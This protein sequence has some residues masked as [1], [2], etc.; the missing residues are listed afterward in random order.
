MTLHNAKGLEY[1]AVFIIGC[2]DGVFPHQRSIDEGDIEEERRLAYVGLTRAREHLALS[3]ARRRTVFGAAGS[4]IPSRFLNEIPDH[5]IER[6][7]TVGPPTGWGLGGGSGGYPS[8]GFSLDTPAASEPTL[9][10]A[11]GDDVVHAAFGEGIVTAV[12]PG[13]VVVVRFGRGGEERK[14]MADY[15]PIQRA[16]S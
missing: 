11:V 3:H 12:E 14:L 5:L 2:E 1:R 10:L 9:E 6:H 8:S 16:A 7:S 15:A 4:G 13:N